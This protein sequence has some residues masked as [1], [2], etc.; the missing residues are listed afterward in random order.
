M[1]APWRG[2]HGLQHLTVLWA[3]HLRYGRTGPMRRP[4]V[5]RMIAAAILFHDAILVPGA[6]D[7]EARSAELWRRAARRLR[8]FTPAEIAWVA[9]TI[10][11]T[12][13]HLNAQRA[14]W[15]EQ[16]AARLWLLDLDLS[17]IG[18][19]AGDLRPQ[20]PRPAGRGAAP[21]RCGLQLGGSE[22]SWG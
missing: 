17:P 12:A 20:R 21:G 5:A 16:G 2:Y 10:R 13:D 6:D 18:D 1:A 7:N 9:D 3:R 11:A 19:E 4:R 14:A 15:I 22:P 8:G